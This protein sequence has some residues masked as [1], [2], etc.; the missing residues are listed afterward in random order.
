[1]ATKA[2]VEHVEERLA[3]RL[4]TAIA[5]NERQLKAMGLRPASETKDRGALLR[6]LDLLGW[7]LQ[8]PEGRRFGLTA[9]GALTSLV[10]AL[11]TT[12]ALV[13]GRLPLP[14]D[15]VPAVQMQGVPLVTP[16]GAATLTAPAEAADASPAHP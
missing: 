9:L 14:H 4:E 8:E 5:Q 10:T 16:A 7:M 3:E 12:Y 15:P 11:G 13:T 6:F 2:M 1:M